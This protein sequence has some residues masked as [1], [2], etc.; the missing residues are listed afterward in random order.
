MALDGVRALIVGDS[1]TPVGGRLGP[2]SAVVSGVHPAQVDADERGVR[3]SGLV[4]VALIVAYA[5]GARW[6]CPAMLPA[7]ALSLWYLPLCTLF[8]GVVI[9]LL[10]V[11]RQKSRR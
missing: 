8:T 5:A 10:L 4:W 2:W 11:E 9:G 1:I 7:A 6:A 3:G